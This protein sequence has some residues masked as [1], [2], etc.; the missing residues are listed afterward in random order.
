MSELIPPTD[1]TDI[2]MLR[3]AEIQSG[4]KSNDPVWLKKQLEWIK[5]V[6]VKL[7]VVVGRSSLTVDTLF[8]LKA[9][10]A[11]VLDTLLDAPVEVLLDGKLVARGLLVAAGDNFG[12]QITDIDPVRY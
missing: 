4:S 7:D 1:S 8:A 11:V 3:L 12:V 9:G 2:A 10:E 6:T 5:D